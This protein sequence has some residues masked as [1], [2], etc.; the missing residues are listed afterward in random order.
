VLIKKLDGTHPLLTDCLRMTVGT[1]AE[2]TALLEALQTV[3]KA[4]G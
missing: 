1:P 3:L 2:N 4:T